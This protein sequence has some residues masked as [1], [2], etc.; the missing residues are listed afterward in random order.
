MTF[1]GINKRLAWSASDEIGTLVK[2]YNRMVDN[3]E[4]SKRALAQSEKELAWR[5]MAK[6]VAHEIKNPLTPMKLT[7]QQ[8]EQSDDL[9]PGKIRKSVEVLLRQVE[10]LNQIA[11]SFSSFTSMPATKPQRVN[12]YTLIRN[13]VSLFQAQ[14][15]GEVI[16]KASGTSP[17]VLIDPTAFSRA[18][19]NM[20]INGLQA[21]KEQEP[22]VTVTISVHSMPQLVKI[23]IQDTGHGMTQEVMDKVF[24]PQFTTKHSGSGLGLALARQMVIQAGGKIWFESV[25][26][27]GTTF[28]VELPAM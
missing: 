3:L 10:I 15:D 11:S 25:L 1:M 17:E 7:L 16:F 5:E 13:T 6:Q 24:Q 12:L 2:E 8:L 20:I 4:E 27:Q 28:Y 26:G 14:E 18:L 21:R 19:S 23:S 22:V 9:S